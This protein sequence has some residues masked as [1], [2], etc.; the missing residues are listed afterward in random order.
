MRKYDR[1]IREIHNRYIRLRIAS[2]ILGLGAFL[3][4]F[5]LLGTIGAV[6]IG[7]MD[8]ADSLKPSLFYLGLFGGC[9]GAGNR[10]ELSI[11]R[12]WRQLRKM[13]DRRNQAAAAV[14]IANELNA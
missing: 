6:E 9:V 1:K 10:L 5:L 8:L 4:F 3:G 12:T 2:F 14:I 13:S 11:H 7:D